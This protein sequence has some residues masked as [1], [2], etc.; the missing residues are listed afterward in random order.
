M[1]TF[2]DIIG[3]LV[4]KLRA[5]AEP[6][7][8]RLLG[9]EVKT[10]RSDVLAFVAVDKE[11]NLHLV[12]HPAPQSGNTLQQFRLKSLRIAIRSW[13]VSG[14]D[15]RDY[16]DVVCNAGGRDDLVRPFVGFCEDILVGLDGGGASPEAVVLKT[17]RRWQNFWSKDLG[18]LSQ[19]AIR[20][21]LG[22]LHF[23]ETIVRAGAPDAVE[24]WVGS[25]GA[26]HD[27]QRGREV[28]F[29]VKTSSQ[30]PY[31][32]TCNLQQLD[33][34]LFSKLFLVCYKVEAS[35]A[36]VSL[37]ETV[38]RVAGRLGSD[39]QALDAFSQR[40]RLAGY[41]AGHEDAY[42]SAKFTVAPAEVFQVTN[43]FPAIT[44]AS[45]TQP[46]DMRIRSLRYT[47]EVSG[48]QGVALESPELLPYLRVMS[49]LRD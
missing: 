6:G 4:A 15:Q 14:Q 45:F 21:L 20:G 9:Q 1:T 27:F 16:I 18:P 48:C 46:P 10:R 12:I 42:A 40:L 33:P 44:L 8:H 22:E 47:L 13:V 41:L 17:A 32:I 39:E 23:L 25:E 30:I 49:S 3:S 19:P 26:D 5:G 31:K 24:A 37:P 38:H 36:G 35:R 29:E 2:G 11:Q 7:T 34:G 43:E 28:A